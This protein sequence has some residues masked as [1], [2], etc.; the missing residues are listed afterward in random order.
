[1]IYNWELDS[2][3]DD[4]KSVLFFIVH[5]SLEPLGYEPNVGWISM[6]KRDLTVKI[7]DTLKRQAPEENHQVFD[8]L[9]EKLSNKI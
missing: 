1:M 7:I 8:S 2:L 5:K 9:K 4:E 6:L 3:T